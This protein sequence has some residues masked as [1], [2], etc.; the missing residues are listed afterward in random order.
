MNPQSNNQRLQQI[1]QLLSQGRISSPEATTSAQ[2]QDPSSD[3]ANSLQTVLGGNNSLGN[4]LQNYQNQQQGQSGG[5]TTGGQGN[6][7]QS[8]INQC[9]RYGE[10]M[11]TGKVGQFA[12]AA[13]AV[14][15]YAKTGALQQGFDNAKPGKTL[16]YFS[17][18]NQPFGHVGVFQGF[19]PSGAPLMRSA[20]GMGIRDSDI[21]QWQQATN[22]KMLGTVTP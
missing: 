20:T 17:D 11:T 1:Q 15:H 4:A 19:S 7:L 22:Q 18:P 14:Q 3:P 21:N 10:L 13:D 2:T 12:S 16:V 9:E 8:F 5:N 6:A